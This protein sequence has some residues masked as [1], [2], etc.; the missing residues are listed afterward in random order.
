[1]DKVIAIFTGR[2]LEEMQKIGGSGHW[3]ANASRIRD[4]KYALLIRNNGERLSPD[5]ISHGQ[6]FMIGKISGC[7]ASKQHPTRKIVQISE[8][9][10]LPNTDNFK[11]AWKKLTSNE[12]T[13]RG[14]R[15]PI[16][17]MNTNDL[18]EKIGLE[19]ES[20]D[21]LPFDVSPTLEEALE[22]EDSERTDLPEIVAE[23]KEMI[24]EAA[25]VDIDQVDIRINF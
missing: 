4:I 3:V 2:D 19:V 20:L 16:S 21:W 24:A 15:Y 13:N 23:A 8:Y 18:L 22:A 11:K 1:M 12:K 5:D 10:L 14:Q 9:S 17:Y 6:A 7:V 25:G